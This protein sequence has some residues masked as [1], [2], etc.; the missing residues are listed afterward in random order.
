MICYYTHINVNETFNQSVLISMF[1][2]WLETSKNRINDLNYNQEKSFEYIEKRKQLLIEDFEE[3]KTF[4]IKFTTSD[5]YKKAQFVVEIM[6]QYELQTLDLRFYKELNEDSKY[7]SAISLPRI[8]MMIL[9]S[10]YVEKDQNLM[11][12]SKPIYMSYKEYNELLNEE[13]E[14]PLVVLTFENKCCINPFKAAEKLLG[15]GHVVCIYSKKKP[16]ISIQYS[17]YENEEI[18]AS[19]EA[20]TIMDC[21]NRLLQYSLQTHDQNDSFDD[22]V[23]DRLYKQHASSQELEEFYQNEY[24]EVK[25]DVDEYEELLVQVQKEYNEI[26]LMKEKLEKKYLTF[27]KEAILFAKENDEQKREF[28]LDLINRTLRTFDNK[29]YR[30]KDVLTSIKKENEND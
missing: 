17:K 21:F 11:I 19:T 7:V 8:F 4:G 3:Y 28:V 14:L 1:L 23:H 9:S 26:V 6:Y 22:L 30:K 15:L 29:A 18:E 12:Q 25:K 10:D 20:K 5:N 13:H 16:S 27:E 2:E 24:E